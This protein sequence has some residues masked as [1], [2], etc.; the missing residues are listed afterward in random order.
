MNGLHFWDYMILGLILAYTVIYFS[1]RFKSK[2]ARKATGM[3]GVG[4]SGHCG[5]CSMQK[6]HASKCSS[7]PRE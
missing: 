4:C 6:E 7:L 5:S 3:N 1:L 2:R